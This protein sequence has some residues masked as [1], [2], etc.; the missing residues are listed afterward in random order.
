MSRRSMTSSRAGGSRTIENQR[1]RS[2]I[3]VEESEQPPDMS[4]ALRLSPA[5]NPGLMGFI[6]FSF[7]SFCSSS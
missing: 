3:V 7:W 6:P 5:E 2:R 1:S 4:P